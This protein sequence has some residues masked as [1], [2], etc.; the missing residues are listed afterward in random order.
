MGTG[1]GKYYIAIDGGDIVEMKSEM[2]IRGKIVSPD[3][4]ET[5]TAI[6]RYYELKLKK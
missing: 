3:G 2:E 6:T 5:D 4:K 1:K